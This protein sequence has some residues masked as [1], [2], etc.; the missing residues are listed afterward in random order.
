MIPDRRLEDATALAEV[1]A[2]AERSA[3][4]DRLSGIQWTALSDA[5]RL[6]MA[7]DAARFRR[8]LEGSLLLVGFT[9][10]DAYLELLGIGP[11]GDLA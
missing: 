10:A 5:E 8:G 11:T 3:G 1:L 4:S 2:E 7:R 9:S 6:D